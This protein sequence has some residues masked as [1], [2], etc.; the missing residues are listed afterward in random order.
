MT[1]EVSEL[2]SSD[3]SS[4]EATAASGDEIL[5]IQRRKEHVKA[6][7]AQHSAELAAEARLTNTER[8]RKIKIWE[9]KKPAARSKKVS[10]VF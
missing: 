7:R 10:R 3:I 6:K 1:E 5:P 2:N 9:E 4:P 8:R